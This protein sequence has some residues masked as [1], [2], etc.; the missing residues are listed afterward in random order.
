MNTENVKCIRLISGE[1]IIGENVFSTE[2]T[3]GFKEP[4]LI[5][6]LP[7]TNDQFSLQ[8]LPFPLII[9]QDLIFPM[10][11][12]NEIIE[13]LK[14]AVILIATPNEEFLSAYREKITGIKV[15]QN[16]GIILP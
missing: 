6:F 12:K 8:L 1:D 9:R 3:F 7:H 13:I 10:P 5:N 16:P 4:H 11:I 14:S 15:V 2:S